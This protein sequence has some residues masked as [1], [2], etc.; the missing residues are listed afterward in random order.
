MPDLELRTATRA[1]LEAVVA[2]LSAQLGEHDVQIPDAV[3]TAAVRGSIDD[4]G[5]RGRILVAREDGALVGVAAL[6]YQ[7]TLEHGGRS[8]WLEELYVVPGGRGRRVGERL[9][10]AALAA[11][12][13]D[14][15]AAVDL[16]VQAGHERV[17]RLYRRE[18][19]SPLPRARWVRRLR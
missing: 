15:A 8:A 10:H 3:L 19:F 6:S 12:A 1:D 17:E 9:L 14:G 4:A 16:E 18:G 7:W 2:L 11:A 5:G 13:N